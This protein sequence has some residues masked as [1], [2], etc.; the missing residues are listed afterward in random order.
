M[1]LFSEENLTKSLAIEKMRAVLE[2]L[3]IRFVLD[4]SI[5]AESNNRYTA[6]SMLTTNLS[7]ESINRFVKV[8]VLK[9]SISTEADRAK[10]EEKNLNTIMQ[11]TFISPAPNRSY[12]ESIM[13]D[14]LALETSGYLSVDYLLSNQVSYENS[15]AVSTETDLEGTI[16]QKMS[17]EA[18]KRST[19]DPIFNVRIESEP[20]DRSNFDAISTATISS[21][22]GLLKINST[23]LDRKLVNDITL[24]SFIRQYADLAISS[25]INLELSTKYRG[26]ISLT[27]SI[28]IVTRIIYVTVPTVIYG[29]LFLTLAY[30]FISILIKKKQHHAFN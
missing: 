1:R 14:Q 16:N 5:L 11:N 6:D 9:S 7:F 12:A 26:D 22:I 28:M 19:E 17:V 27:S 24:E 30:Y 21:D 2:E 23:D 29:I 13:I 20:T 25:T 15:N 10:G 4:A 8:S 18:S 3:N